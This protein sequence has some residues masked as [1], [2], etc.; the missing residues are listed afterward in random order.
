MVV[1]RGESATTNTRAHND[2]THHAAQTSA[3]GQRR[4]GGDRGAGPHAARPISDDAPAENGGSGRLEAVA[5]EG[6]PTRWGPGEGSGRKSRRLRR[7]ARAHLK[8]ASLNMKGWGQTT[9]GVSEKWMRINQMMKEKKIAILALQET[10]LN[11]ERVATLN[12]IFAKHIEVVHSEDP[13]NGTG[14]RGVAFVINKRIIKTP[15]YSTMTVIPGRALLLDIAWSAERNLRVMNVYAPNAARENTDMWRQLEQTGPTRVDILLGDFNVTEDALD[16]LPARMDAPEPV[17]ALQ[18]LKSKLKVS[19]GW[20]HAHTGQVSFTYQHTNGTTQSRLDRI[21]ATRRTRKDADNWDHEEPGIETDHR[22]AYIEIADHNA[23]FVGKGRWTMPQHLLRDEHMKE[24]M[25]EIA[26]RLI[27]EIDCIGERTAERNPQTAYK[28]FK[29]DLTAAARKRAK[30]KIPKIQRQMESLRKD[31]EELLRKVAERQ[32]ARVEGLEDDE[33]E[34][35]E[36]RAAIIQDRITKLEQ[37]RFETARRSTATKCKV[38]AE[39]LTKA[40]I[41]ANYTP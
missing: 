37:K 38:N 6:R 5:E 23:P 9:R 20:R 12:D 28:T 1:P 22:L 16:R 30:A 13:L 18:S 40:W 31:R 25:V 34:G 41:R 14:A 39:T 32:N 8:V 10:H 4:L 7:K 24:K 11:N 2:N 35:L 15:E 29:Q 17:E 3:D 26:A 19:D 36:R 33:L 27:D 21:Y